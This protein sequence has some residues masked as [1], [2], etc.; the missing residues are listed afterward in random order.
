VKH[1]APAGITRVELVN[2]PNNKDFLDPASYGYLL[3]KAYPAIKEVA[4]SVR[5]TSGAILTTNDA[6]LDYLAAVYAI[7]VNGK[8][9]HV[10][11][12][13]AIA[14]WD[15]TKAMWKTAGGTPWDDI[16]IHLYQANATYGGTPAAL[17]GFANA[18]SAKVDSFYAVVM[19]GEQLSA[20]QAH[21]YNVNPHFY[22]SEIGWKLDPAQDVKR[23]EAQ[24]AA[25]VTAVLGVLRKNEHI[26]MLSY[27]DFADTKDSGAFGLF[28][29]APYTKANARPSFAAFCTLLGSSSCLAP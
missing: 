21:R 13:T 26:R 16:G 28:R 29:S 17:S 10:A 20:D 14:G 2:E 4:P 24:Q 7:G 27:F 6:N 1:L 11:N 9:A 19:A 22:V 12:Q 15:D 5:I 18:M 8:D 23:E 3:G 25:R